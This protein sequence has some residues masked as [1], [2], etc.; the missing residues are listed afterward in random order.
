MKIINE[1]DNQVQ[2]TD[3]NLDGNSQNI[4]FYAV[5]E[6]DI[7]MNF[8]EFSDIMGPVKLVASNP[9]KTP[10]IKRIMPI[11]ENQ[12]LGIKPAVQIELNAYQPQSKIKKINI[13]RAETML[14]AQSIRTMKLVREITIDE[15]TLSADFENVWTVYDDFQDLEYIPFGDGLFYRITVSKQIEYADSESTTDNPVINIDYAPSQPSK[16]TATTIVDTVSPESPTLEA[17]GVSSGTNGAILKPVVFNWEKTVYNGKY[18]LYKMNNQGNWEK[19][20]EISTNLE[21]ITL[22]LLETNPKTDELVIKDE[23][24]ERIYHHFKVIAENSSGMLSSDEKIL[25]L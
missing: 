24:E 15:N 8:G 22:P 11:L 9:P 25:T 18:H 14:G 12:V 20:H 3:F 1:N 4:Y 13:Y 10:E 23:N 2:F 19:I 21:N 16:I 17:S 6:M 7:K 5:R